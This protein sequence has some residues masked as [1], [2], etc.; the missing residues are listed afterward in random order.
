MEV[1][2]GNTLRVPAGFVTVKAAVTVG[3][4]AR[5]YCFANKQVA[6]MNELSARIDPV[7]KVEK[8]F[9]ISVKAECSCP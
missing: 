2:P 3:A 9:W 4:Y 6:I 5:Q 7:L 1:A 8:D